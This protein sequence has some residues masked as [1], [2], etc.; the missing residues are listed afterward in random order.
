MGKI[1]A[2]AL[3]TFRE[4]V[5]DKVLY[6]MLLL[7]LVMIGT[8]ALVAEL[9]LGSYEKIIK[10]IGLSAISVFGILI[11]IFIG[12]GLVSKEIERKT[13]YTIASK[14]VRRWQFLTGK[15]LGLCM[16]L[17]VELVLMSIAFFLT[18]LVYQGNPGWELIPALW[19]TLIE[20]LLVTSVAVT[21]SCFTSPMLA[22]MFSVGLT[23]IGRITPELILVGEQ[24]NNPALEKVARVLYRVLPDL[25][26]FDIRGAA[27][28]GKAI[29]WEFVA[30]TTSYGLL[31]VV[32]LLAVASLIFQRRDFK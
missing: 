2:I 16:T 13:I 25:S 10:D 12:I 3:N 32:L 26:S 7:A 1:R 20:M 24:S 23:L 14:P 8:S 9:A 28:Y 31:W 22:A 11:S 5:R 21:F 29:E 30:Y 17:T 4:S 18:L 15:Y 19:L 6:S 27:A